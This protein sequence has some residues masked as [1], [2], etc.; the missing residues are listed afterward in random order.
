MLYIKCYI[1]SNGEWTHTNKQQQE[2]GE[3]ILY[4]EGLIKAKKQSFLFELPTSALHHTEE[5][6][7]LQY[8]FRS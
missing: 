6:T 5:A 2:G 4:N 3:T 1:K 7:L 8:L